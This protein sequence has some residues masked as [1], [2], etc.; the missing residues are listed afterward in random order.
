MAGTCLSISV[1]SAARSAPGKGRRVDEATCRLGSTLLCSG[2]AG[3]QGGVEARAA[4]EARRVSMYGPLHRYAGATLS[5][6]TAKRS[7]C[8]PSHG[9]DTVL[10][11]TRSRQPHLLRPS[12]LVSSAPPPPDSATRPRTRPPRDDRRTC[13]ARM[14]RSRRPHLEDE[15]S[16]LLVASCAP[17]WSSVPLP[18]VW[19]PR[20]VRR[21]SA[22][23][24]K[25]LDDR[26]LG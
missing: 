8:G 17:R 3:S 14:S 6:S 4:V 26:R 20:F 23:A 19:Q 1:W 12:G 13:A 25:G 21:A 18:L 7:L 2:G 22:F 24:E 15:V 10:D 16:A 9:S 5:L 11:P